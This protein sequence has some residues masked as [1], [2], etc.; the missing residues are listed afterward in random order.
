MRIVVNT[1][2]YSR[3]VPARPQIRWGQNNYRQ[4]NLNENLNR[5]LQCLWWLHPLYCKHTWLTCGWHRHRQ[6]QTL[7]HTMNARALAFF[8]WFQP[9]VASVTIFAVTN[10]AR[11]CSWNRN[12]QTWKENASD[13]WN[14]E[15]KHLETSIKSLTTKIGGWLLKQV[16][17][18]SVIVINK[19][20]FA[21][22]AKRR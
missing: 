7:S 21:H 1:T 11:H 16:N 12:D 22:F 3:S 5:S 4:A 2:L 8:A 18:T 6:G 9:H 19:M 10:M 14:I 17:M 20:L 15:S 13:I